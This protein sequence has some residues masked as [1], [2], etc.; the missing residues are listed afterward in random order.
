MSFQQVV[1]GKVHQ[2]LVTAGSAKSGFD[3]ITVDGK[4][5]AVGESASFGTFSVVYTT[6][7]HAAIT[8]ES[9]EFQLSNSDKFINQAVSNRVA[10]SKLNAHGLL[11]QTSVAKVYSGANRYIQGEVD[12]Y[13]I[14]DNDIFGT[15]FAYNKFQL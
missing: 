9:F 11:G 13:V 6:S 14:A 15:D 7:H 12:D 1:D 3:A 10:L 4:A 8:T 5:L 2:I